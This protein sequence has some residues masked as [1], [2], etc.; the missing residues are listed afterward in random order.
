M[1]APDAPMWWL[2]LVTGI[3]IGLAI[4]HRDTVLAFAARLLEGRD[5]LPVWPATPSVGQTGAKP[6]LRLIWTARPP[7]DREQ[8]GGDAA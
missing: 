6:H 5:H 3:V 7:Y 1:I 8:E 2:G 4:A